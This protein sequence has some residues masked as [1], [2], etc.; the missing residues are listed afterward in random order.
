MRLSRQKFGI[1]EIG[2]GFILAV[3]IGNEVGDI[4]G[5]ATP[6]RLASYAGTVPRVHSSGGL[7][8][9]SVIIL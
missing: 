5:F 1:T 6:R 9:V 8:A 2:I 7:N 3:A 4:S